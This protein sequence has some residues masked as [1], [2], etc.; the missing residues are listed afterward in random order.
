LVDALGEQLG[1]PGLG[2]VDTK[3]ELKLLE[4][5]GRK[6]NRVSALPISRREIDAA[7]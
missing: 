3:A 5:L 4:L 1:K 2:T 7:A 6:L